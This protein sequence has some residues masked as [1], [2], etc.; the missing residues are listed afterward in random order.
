MLPLFTR[1]N[2]DQAVAQA[3]MSPTRAAEVSTVELA[4]E[5]SFGSSERGADVPPAG[6]GTGRLTVYGGPL[7]NSGLTALF[8]E[9]MTRGSLAGLAD[10]RTSRGHDRMRARATASGAPYLMLDRGLLRAPPRYGAASTVL[11]VT[12]VEMEGPSSPADVLS[13]V[14]LLARRGWETSALLERARLARCELIASRIGGSWWGQGALPGGDGIAVV[15]GETS[16]ASRS[17]PVLRAMLAAALAENPAQKVVVLV[18]PGLRGSELHRAAIRDGCN[19]VTGPV[20]SWAAVE[21]ADRVYTTGGE[22][23]FLALLA[24]CDVHC[25]GDAFYSGWGITRDAS[26]VALRPFLRGIDE[27][28]AGACLVATRYLD[29]YRQKRASFEDIASMLADWRKIDQANR[30][31]AVCVGMSFWKRRRV[32]DFFRSGAGAPVFRNS[33]R[34]ALATAGAKPA[35]AVALWA[36]RA[37]KDFVAAAERRQIPI[38]WVEDGFIRSVSLGSDFVPAASL[39]L[40]SRG[41]HYNPSVETDL[42]RILLKTEFDERMIRRARSLIV[43]LVAR[44]ITKYNLGAATLSLD[45]PGDRRRILGPDKSKTISRCCSTVV[46]LAATSICCA[47]S[48]PPTPTRLFSTSRIPMST[49][50]TAR[51]PSRIRSRAISPIGS[52]GAPRQQRCSTKST[53]CTRSPRFLGSRHCCAG[54]GSRFTAA[55]SMPVGV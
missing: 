26:N 46:R 40:D 37:P 25:F 21:R 14:R 49:P 44:G 54:A 53:N 17:V 50:G 36:S 29:P 12:A 31:V 3:P 42:Q 11:S 45:L 19:V 2:S 15:D 4:T 7:R 43:Q 55:P 8:P 9:F 10:W 39:V 23:G 51:V 24:D 38:V 47:V 16:N 35:R 30:R 18:P 13:P 27:I 1:S 52:F 33:T 34:R 32:A 20:D 41:M 28:F 6:A 48:E 5:A 22:I